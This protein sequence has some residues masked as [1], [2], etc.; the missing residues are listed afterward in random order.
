MSDLYAMQRANGD[1][2]AFDDH[3][4]LSMPVFHGRNEAM[5]ARSRHSEMECFRPMIFDLRALQDLETADGSAPFFWI[6][7]D[8]AIN[9][10]RGRALDLDQFIQLIEDLGTDGRTERLP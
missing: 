10:K 9:L 4:R 8:P 5:I 2:F 6:V 3:G 7:R 1:W